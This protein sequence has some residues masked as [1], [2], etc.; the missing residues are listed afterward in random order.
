M[1]TVKTR[2]DKSEISG[3]GLFASQV[4]LPGDVVWKMSSISVLKISKIQYELLSDIEQKFIKEKD[5]YWL[6]DDGNYMIPIDD[7]RFINHSSSPNL[8][9]LDD[10]HYIASRKI[11]P[12]EELT[13][14][15]KKLVPKE[16]WEAYMI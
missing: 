1:L 6:D 4:I 16:Y 9:E 12:N 7:G 14:D 5:Y 8:V 11:E 10:N 13:I 3:I 2:L 15:Y